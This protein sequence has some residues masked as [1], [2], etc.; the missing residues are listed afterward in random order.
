MSEFKPGDRVRVVTWGPKGNESPYVGVTG[1]VFDDGPDPEGTNLIAVK[2][3]AGTD[4]DMNGMPLQ[5]YA[6]E[7]EKVE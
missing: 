4:P 3:D 2:V 7:I 1:T 6:D 5:C